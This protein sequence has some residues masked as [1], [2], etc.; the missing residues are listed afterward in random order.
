[1]A[2][3]QK[4]VVIRQ[5]IIEMVE[6]HPSD[7]ATEAA[8]EFG[9]SRQAAWQHIRK[10]Q[11]QGV[12]RA[13]GKTSSRKYSLVPLARESFSLQ[14]L[15]LNED[16]VWRKQVLPLLAGVRESPLDTCYIAFSEM[17][18][19]NELASILVAPAQSAAS[20]KSRNRER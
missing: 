18:K 4:T 2:E 12:L 3:R 8:R 1:M 20:E 9:I 6:R 11:S 5:F 13:E 17:L 15:D 19:K 7:I 14:L 10:L 16:L